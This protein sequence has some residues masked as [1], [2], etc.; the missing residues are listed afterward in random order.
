MRLKESLGKLGEFASA[1]AKL[2]IEPEIP[3]PRLVEPMSWQEA[4]QLD[5]ATRLTMQ[6][7]LP[8]PDGLLYLKDTESNRELIEK[9][10]TSYLSKTGT[11][12]IV[13]PITLK[14]GQNVIDLPLLHA[15]RQIASSQELRIK[16]PKLYGEKADDKGEPDF[17]KRGL[18]N[19]EAMGDFA[20]ARKPSLRVQDR[21]DKSK[22]AGGRVSNVTEDTIVAVKTYAPIVARTTL[23]IDRELSQALHTELKVVSGQIGGV[24]VNGAKHLASESINV[25]GEVAAAGDENQVDLVADAIANLLVIGLNVSKSKKG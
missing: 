18:E 25:L 22:T 19:Q 4:A 16:I 10:Y 21:Q 14:S 20:L 7:F 6:D 23:K 5:M 24:A 15:Q 3:Q 2:G 11:T 1:V 9:L 8:D 12:P 17:C 13:R